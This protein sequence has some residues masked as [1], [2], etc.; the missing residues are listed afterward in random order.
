MKVDVGGYYEAKIQVRPV[1]DKVIGYIYNQVDKTENV[2][3]VKIVHIQKGDGVDI[4]LDS[5]RFAVQ[6]GRKL[7]KVFKGEMLVTRSIYGVNKVTSKT[8]YRV[9]VLFRLP[10]KDATKE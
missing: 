6:L 3:I 10:K 2:S 9:T 8:I 5:W 1:D 4:Y 7:K